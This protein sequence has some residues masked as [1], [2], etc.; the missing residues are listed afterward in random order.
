MHMKIILSVYCLLIS[1]ISVAIGLD[2]LTPPSPQPAPA[3]PAEIQT[4]IQA[5]GSPMV[6]PAAPTV[7][8]PPSAPT[9][10]VPPSAPATAD[11]PAEPAPVVRSAI[12][13]KLDDRMFFAVGFY[14]VNAKLTEGEWS[15]N[16][17]A[18]IQFAYDPRFFSP[19][20]FSMVFDFRYSAIDTSA[21]IDSRSYGGVIEGLGLGAQFGYQ[22]SNAWLPLFSVEPT[23]YRISLH[24]TDA[25]DLDG[26]G[27]QTKSGLL[28][29]VG[30][31]YTGKE[32]VRV[33][34]RILASVG[35][36]KTAQYGVSGSFVF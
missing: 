29:G 20:K 25:L 33:G 19:G 26:Q 22:A 27:K 12:S 5:P 23:L 24:S 10:P 34:P 3:A 28:L 17:M 30:L 8:A 18:D 36:V 7:V 2:D 14:R 11:A 13:Q 1:S 31:D 4:P 15:S 35:T 32:K 6:G 21:R 9:V 16:G